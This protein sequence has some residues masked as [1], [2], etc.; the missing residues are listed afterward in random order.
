MATNSQ[1][2]YDLGA[3]A[4]GAVA[5]ETG[6]ADLKKT[7]TQ[8]IE[9]CRSALSTYAGAQAGAFTDVMAQVERSGQIIHQELDKQS[10][11]VLASTNSYSTTDHESA[12]VIRTVPLDGIL[13][14]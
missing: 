3:G 2:Q 1:Y 14:V 6:A 13:N 5:F 8:A 7:V 4:K 11:I 9:E 10:E 12:Q